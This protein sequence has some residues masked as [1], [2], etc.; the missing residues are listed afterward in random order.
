VLIDSLVDASWDWEQSCPLAVMGWMPI[1]SLRFYKLLFF[2][3]ELLAENLL[4]TLG[5]STLG[6]L[7]DVL[8]V[9]C[10]SGQIVG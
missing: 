5:L 7:V 2:R 4:S 9:S 1:R 6:D 8:R 3:P 10:L